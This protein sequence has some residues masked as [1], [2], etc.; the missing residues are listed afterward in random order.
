MR[1]ISSITNALSYHAV[2]NSSNKIWNFSCFATL[3]SVI[4]RRE[5]SNNFLTRSKIIP[6]PPHC[7]KSVQIRGF[8]WSVFSRIRTR[9]RFVFGHFSRSARQLIFFEDFCHSIFFSCILIAFLTSLTY[10]FPRRRESDWK[11]TYDALPIFGEFFYII[12]PK[13]T[14]FRGFKMETLARMG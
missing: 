2:T 13:N 1:K 7:V 14:F 8:F 9:N 10:M 3:T 12:P 11:F 4:L 6:P 5:S